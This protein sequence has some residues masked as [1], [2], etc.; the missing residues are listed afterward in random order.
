[1]YTLHAKV[2]GIFPGEFQKQLGDRFHAGPLGAAVVQSVAI[3]TQ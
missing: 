3:L 1:M 2:V